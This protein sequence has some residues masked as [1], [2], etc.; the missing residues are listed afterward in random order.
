MGGRGI[1]YPRATVGQAVGHSDRFLGG[2]IG[3]TEHDHIDARHQGALGLRVFALGRI[4]ADQLHAGLAGQT[5]TDPKTCGAR[6][7]I[8]ENPCHRP[9]PQIAAAS[10]RFVLSQSTQKKSPGM[11]GLIQMLSVRFFLGEERNQS[12]NRG[13]DNASADGEKFNAVLYHF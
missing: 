11:P 4:N 1:Q 9:A 7:A 3:Q 10:S 5:F 6:L 12:S 8:D 2:I 13:Q